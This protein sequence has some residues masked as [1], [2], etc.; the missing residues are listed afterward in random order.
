MVPILTI[1][2]EGE[3]ILEITKAPRAF[4][5]LFEIKDALVVSGRT[6]DIHQQILFRLT[7]L[8]EEGAR[9]G[10]DGKFYCILRSRRVGFEGFDGETEVTVGL[11]FSCLDMVPIFKDGQMSDGYQQIPPEDCLKWGLPIWDPPYA[12]PR[13]SRYKRTPVI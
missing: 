6:L 12:G 4:V 13:P 8:A 10:S 11:S 1:G 2:E 3:N 9:L 5:P 7:A